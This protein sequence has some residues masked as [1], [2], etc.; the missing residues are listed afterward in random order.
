MQEIKVTL[1]SEDQN[2]MFLNYLDS[3]IKPLVKGSFSSAGFEDGLFINRTNLTLE[4]D[5]EEC[6]VWFE[7]VYSI[8]TGLLVSLKYECEEKSYIEDKIRHFIDQSFQGI[9]SDKKETYYKRY[10]YRYIGGRLNGEYYKGRTLRVAP[11]WPNQDNARTDIERYFSID[12]KVEAVD[13]GDANVKGNIIADKMAAK[14]SFWLN[15][16]IDEGFTVQHLWGVKHSDGDLEDCLFQRCVP[17]AAA[18]VPNEMPNKGGIKSGET[19]CFNPDGIQAM[20]DDIYL[21]DCWKKLL[22]ALEK[23]SDDIN[24]AY[25]NCCF[26]YQ[27][28]MNAGRYHPTVQASYMVSAIESL[29]KSEEDNERTSFSGFIRFYC[30]L[31]KENKNTEE[32][33]DFLYSKIR[34]K[35]F[36]S[37]AFEAGEYDYNRESTIS[38]QNVSG[39]I[40]RKKLDIGRRLIRIAIYNWGV[41]LIKRVK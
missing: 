36:H 23:S 13:H 28:A 32:V 27:M 24:K 19:R 5:E 12:L 30:D 8:Q 18:L 34:S 15:L 40:L 16:G 7:V 33:L 9:I 14:L 4:I 29:A 31:T 35:H 41:D 26:M 37:G 21:P 3:H 20:M 25:D 6:R 38:F 22:A 11:Y 1:T 2:K 10:L 39:T 17:Q